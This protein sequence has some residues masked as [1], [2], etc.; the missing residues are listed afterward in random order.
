VFST[1]LDSLIPVKKRACHCSHNETRFESTISRD[2]LE[3]AS[4]LF[5]AGT[6]AEITP[7][8][9]VNDIA[10]G[11]GTKDLVTDEI[12]SRF[13]DIVAGRTD[14]YKEWFTPV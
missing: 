9:S 13:F 1:W 7:I 10:I 2:K 11:N 4:E 12:Q 5:F 6:A 3:T 8:R 14:D